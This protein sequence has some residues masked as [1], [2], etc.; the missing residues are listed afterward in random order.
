[1]VH[2]MKL[3]GGLDP[4]VRQP[5][6]EISKIKIAASSGSLALQECPY[7]PRLKWPSRASG[8]PRQLQPEINI[9]SYGL[10]LTPWRWSLPPISEDSLLKSSIVDFDTSMKIK[11]ET[12]DTVK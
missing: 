9:F 2:Q 4:S 1:M 7:S 11:L 5:Q 8:P 12:V 3:S 6:R 10:I